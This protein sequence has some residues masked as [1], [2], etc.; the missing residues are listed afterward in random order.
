MLSLSSDTASQS[1]GS[2]LSLPVSHSNTIPKAK[3]VL[4]LPSQHSKDQFPKPRS[5]ASAKTGPGTACTG[6]HSRASSSSCSKTPG[7]NAAAKQAACRARKPAEGQVAI[8]LWQ[9][10]V[11]QIKFKGSAKYVYDCKRRHIKTRHPTE[12]Y[13]ILIG[14]AQITICEASENLPAEARAWQCPCCPKALPALP[15]RAAHLAVNA[16]RRKFHPELTTK[17]W[18]SKMVSL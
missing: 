1:A 5:A 3:S 11:C 18:R 13:S 9:C 12:K 4:S 6:P 15:K 14:K 10:P 16:H 17:E 7:R 8:T 2:R